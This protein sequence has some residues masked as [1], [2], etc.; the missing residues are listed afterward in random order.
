MNHWFRHSD[1]AMRSPFL[2]VCLSATVWVSALPFQTQPTLA[3]PVSTQ[4]M[5]QSNQAIVSLA[6]HLKQTGAKMYGAYWCPHCQHQKELFG[7]ATFDRYINYIEC[8]PQGAHAKPQ[9]CK[10]AKITGYPTWEIKGKRYMGTQTL[11][12]LANASGYKG[13]RDFGAQR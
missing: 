4:P 12:E 11:E 13:S 5:V 3:E 1:R 10:A 2:I 7:Q 8:D 9:V 6:R